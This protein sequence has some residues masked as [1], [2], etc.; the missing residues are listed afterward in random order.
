MTDSG[1]KTVQN[2]EDATKDTDKDTPP[3]GEDQST[4]PSSSKGGITLD[5]LSLP[6]IESIEEFDPSI[7]AVNAD[8]TPRRKVDGSL[9]RRRGRKGGTSSSA[10]GEKQKKTT[11]SSGS[12]AGIDMTDYA[13]LGDLAAGM[14]AATGVMVFGAEWDFRDPAERQGMAMAYAEYMRA[15]EIRDIPPGMVLTM[16]LVSYSVPRLQLPETQSRMQKIG[17]WIK[18]KIAGRKFSFGA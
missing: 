6:G 2:Q 5:T 8:G 16:V 1:E 17:G 15:K 18:S 13:V 11:V 4:T 7:H 14:T 3:S 9:A 12:V 10:S